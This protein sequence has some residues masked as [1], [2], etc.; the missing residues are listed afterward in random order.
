MT[1]L[2]VLIFFSI[3]LFTGCGVN[4]VYN[5]TRATI[6][7]DPSAALQSLATSKAINY[8][9]NPT[10]LSKDIKALS[11][12]IEKITNNWGN[13]NVKIPKQ[14]EYVKYMQNY[15]SRALIDFDNGIVTV[16]TIDE[17]NP[18]DSLQNAIVTTLL[19]PDD[20]R[21]A[22]LFGASEI[23]LGSTPYLLGEVKDDQNKDI[24][25]E[26]RANRFAEILIKNSFKQKKVKVESKEVKVS[27]VTIPMVKD[28]TSIRVA[29]VKPIVE[30]YS[31]KYGVSRN[32]I[33][34]IIKTESNFNQFAVSN[35]GA[36]GLMQIVPSSA[37]KDAYEYVKG[38]N[39]EP[40]TSYLFN[41]QNNI[42]LGT[43]YLK[44]LNNQYLGNIQNEV[45]KEYCVISAYN[46]GS[47]NVLR[48]FSDNRTK[49][50]NIINSKSALEVYN[51]L[52]SDLPYEETRRYLK[53]VIDSKKEFTNI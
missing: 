44:M 13:D 18:K 48:T 49:A 19:L 30:K 41:A 38:K 33:Y 42:E 10:K 21:A 28:H 46:T 27:Y 7:K 39:S 52:K 20:P 29:K 32:L 4:D 53:K 43:A 25:Y 40:S 45:S 6:S 24:R 17:K 5:I 50:V 37:G 35:A 9:S 31:Q 22:D 47:G 36:Y 15:K 51:T 12:F 2:K 11:S 23:K 26:W 8:A 14:K 34:A 1:R 16:E 3:F